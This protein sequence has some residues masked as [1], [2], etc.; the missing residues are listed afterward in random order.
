MEKPFKKFGLYNINIEYLAALHKQD[1]EVRYSA[2]LNYGNKPYVGVIVAFK[3]YYYFIP[4]TSA[5]PKYTKWKNVAKSHYLIYE[6]VSEREVQDS[7]VIKRSENGNI[8]IMSALEIHKMIPVPVNCFERIDFD[9]VQDDR[10]KALLL[11]EFLFLQNVQDSIYKK[12]R[13][14]YDRQIQT[15]KIFNQYCNFKLLEKFCA[16]WAK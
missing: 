15:G 16:G 13:D 1:S 3:G 10:Y 12:A 9:S 7:D 6:K 5:K 14:I 11:K 2:N 4:L 8:K